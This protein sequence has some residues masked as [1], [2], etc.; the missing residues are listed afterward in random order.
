MPRWA[1]WRSPYFAA[2]PDLRSNATPDYA[3]SLEVRQQAV[4]RM[5]FMIVLLD[6]TLRTFA[7][8]G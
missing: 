2:R 6:G 7:S 4:V 5:L 8:E 3:G 1:G